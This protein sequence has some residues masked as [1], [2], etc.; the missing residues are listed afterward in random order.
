MEFGGDRRVAYLDRN[1]LLDADQ[2][3]ERLRKARSDARRLVGLLPDLEGVSARTI[4]DVE[5]AL[6]VLN[7]D[8]ERLI[9]RVRKSAAA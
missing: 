7:K 5:S 3:L 9:E 6:Q 1:A 8:L 2:A 4:A